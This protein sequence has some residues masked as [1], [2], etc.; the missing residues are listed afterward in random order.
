[1]QRTWNT[2]PAQD[3]EVIGEGFNG[4]VYRIDQDNVVKVYKNANALA[5][6][7]HEREVAR[8]AMVLG[9]PTAI[10]Y[11]VVRVRDSYGSVFELLNARSLP[12]TSSWQMGRCC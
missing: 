1:M 6:I 5:D 4:K 3:C 10:S 7:Q 8:L 12:K 11:D 9:V 2:S